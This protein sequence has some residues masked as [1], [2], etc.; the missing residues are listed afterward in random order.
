MGDSD[1][2]LAVGI[3]GAIIFSTVA[4]GIALIAQGLGL[5]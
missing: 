4:A 1:P 3:I 5:S 2:L